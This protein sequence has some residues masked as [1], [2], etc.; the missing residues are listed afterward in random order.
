MP[1]GSPEACDWWFCGRVARA[2]PG[3]VPDEAVKFYLG[4]L[5]EHAHTVYSGPLAASWWPIGSGEAECDRAE[6]CAPFTLPPPLLVLALHLVQLG[7]P[8]AVIDVR[9]DHGPH[10]QAVRLRGTPDAQF[11][12]SVISSRF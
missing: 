7:E 6:G 12:R 8:C 11:V 2:P 9:A 5:S 1:S 4:Q 3:E 10:V